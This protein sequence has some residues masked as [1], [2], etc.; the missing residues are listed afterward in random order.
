MKRYLKTGLLV[1]FVLAMAY[2]LC[3]LVE[4]KKIMSSTK[5]F[6]H[7][8]ITFN[9]FPYDNYDEKQDYVFLL[10][11]CCENN[12]VFK[13]RDKNIELL[14]VNY[15]GNYETIKYK[16][17]GDRIVFWINGEPD[18][19][20]YNY[21]RRNNTYSRVYEYNIRTSKIEEI[22]SNKNENII[23]DVIKDDKGY[24]FLVNKAI[25][26]DSN[27]TWIKS[28]LSI[29]NHY[30]DEIIISYESEFS[31]SFLKINDKY[32]IAAED[33]LYLVD[34]GRRKIYEYSN[35]KFVR[36][37]RN[38]ELIYAFIDNKIVMFNSSFEIIK[39]MEY[40]KNFAYYDLYIKDKRFML[41]LK[42]QEDK[43]CVELDNNL[44]N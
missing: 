31:G 13:V 10:Q 42:N 9:T 21:I 28:A 26:V 5:N 35:K 43:N 18:I 25:E 6:N 39:E 14:I 7:Q 2:V 22:Y 37:I 23:I 12:A 27:G 11:E 38:D 40:K 36:M 33:G 3:F 34:D 1:A 32:I 24:V 8:N 29:E 30:F 17:F 19:Y 20:S 16:V 41:C 4:F 44:N 15:D